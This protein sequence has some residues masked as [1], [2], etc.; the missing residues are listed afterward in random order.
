[1]KMVRRLPWALSLAMPTPQSC[2]VAGISDI[3]QVSPGTMCPH[4]LGASSWLARWLNHNWAMEADGIPSPGS[5]NQGT[6]SSTEKIVPVE[7]LMRLSTVTVCPH[8]IHPLTSIC[9]VLDEDMKGQILT[10]PL[11]QGTAKPSR[12]VLPLESHHGKAGQEET[13]VDVCIRRCGAIVTRGVIKTGKEGGFSDTVRTGRFQLV[14]PKTYPH[15]TCTEVC[16]VLEH[17]N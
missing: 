14:E 16:V 1:M 7:I 4:L 11:L 2:L 13:R 3:Q 10:Y 17:N 6:C 15:K 8:I 12:K 9:K 5:C